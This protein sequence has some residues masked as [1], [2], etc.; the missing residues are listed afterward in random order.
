MPLSDTACRGAKPGEKQRKMF[1]GGGLHLLVK[2]TGSRLWRLDYRFDGKFKTLSFGAYPEVSLGDARE[3]RLWAKTLLAQGVDPSTRRG[4]SQAVPVGERFEDLSREWYARRYRTRNKYADS[5]LAR[6]VRDIFPEIGSMRITAI[7]APVI[8]AALRKAE[9]RGVHDVV[10]RLLW[11]VEQIFTFAI[12]SGRA[13][14][15]PALGLKPA[16]ETR[17]K[18]KHMARVEVAELPK[19]LDDIHG[20]PGREQTRLA[21]ETTLHTAVRTNELRF[22]RWS[23][24]RGDV[25][26]IPADRMKML[27]DHIV[28]LT[29]QAVA[30][31]GRL[32]KIAAGSE[33]IVPGISGEPISQNTMINALYRLGYRER[34]TI[35]GFRGLFSTILNERKRELGFDTDWIELQLAHVEQNRVRGAYNA[36]EY[37]SDRRRMML[38]WSGYLDQQAD[39]G[40]LL[41]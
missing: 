36:A 18:P 24:I 16:L 31:L 28:P 15:N 11:S 10:G 37:L 8:L 2:P 9:A 21:I 25:W 38:W 13:V 29:P 3:R 12:A 39:L 14:R 20:Y 34:Q 19:L 33:W 41:G 6:L 27:R 40:E 1:D 32:R 30:R 26:R 5:V 4:K 23:E 7:E 22:G 35:H 17:P